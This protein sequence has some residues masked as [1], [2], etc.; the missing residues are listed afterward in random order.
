M[1]LSII[2]TV[3]AVL[4]TAAA[5]NQAIVIN[6]CSDP[7]YVQ[8]YPYDGGK[9]GTLTAVKPGE[10]FS[11]DL[12]SAGSV[13]SLQRHIFSLCFQIYDCSSYWHRTATNP[14]AW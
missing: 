11:E 10:R 8:S 1:K 5:A 6:D 14:R 4:G 3:S 9:P 2:A 13:R 12:L 7:I